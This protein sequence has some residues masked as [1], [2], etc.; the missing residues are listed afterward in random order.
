ML[1]TTFSSFVDARKFARL[2]L[3]KRLAACVNI[4]PKLESWYWWKEKVERG[5]E[6]LL[7]IKTSPKRLQELVTFFQENHPYQ[8][9]ESIALTIDWGEPNYLR[10]LAQSLK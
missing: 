6:A 3:E 5:E 7:L 10:W 2:L 4:V 8:L 1:L 9:P